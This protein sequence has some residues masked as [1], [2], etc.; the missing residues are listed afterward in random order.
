MVHHTMY[1]AWEY[2]EKVV[3]NKLAPPLFDEALGAMVELPTLL[4]LHDVRK[5]QKRRE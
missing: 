3:S 2:Y 5:R 1:I 4:G